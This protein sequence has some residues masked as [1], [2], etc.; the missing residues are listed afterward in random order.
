MGLA[1]PERDLSLLPDD[2][3]DLTHYAELTG[4]APGATALALYRL[5]WSL[6]DMAE[7]VYSFRGPH[8]RTFDGPSTCDGF[9]EALT[10][11]AG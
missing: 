9:N 7:F 3:A 8:E 11:L 2:P 5:R 1:V 6:L 4:R 10:Q